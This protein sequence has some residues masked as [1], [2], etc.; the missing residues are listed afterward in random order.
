MN[1]SNVIFKDFG[2]FLVRLFS[3]IILAYRCVLIIT[4]FDQVNQCF[5]VFHCQ[6]SANTQLIP[7]FKMPNPP[8]QGFTISVPVLIKTT[9]RQL[10]LTEKCWVNP[11]S[12]TIKQ[13]ITTVKLLQKYFN[14]FIIFR[15]QIGIIF[16]FN[17]FHLPNQVSLNFAD[18]LRL[19]SEEHLPTTHGAWSMIVWKIMVK[20]YQGF[21]TEWNRHCVSKC[22][23][24]LIRIFLYWDWIRRFTVN[25]RI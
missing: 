12:K 14:I 17:C 9:F 19:A 8:I 25:L 5:I 6:L 3:W 2:M 22:G 4:N 1:L 23:S 10:L 16:S 21:M 15:F 13:S 11:C 24:F 18:S 7:K 20:S